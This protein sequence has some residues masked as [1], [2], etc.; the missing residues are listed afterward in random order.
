MK[1][2]VLKNSFYGVS[3][4]VSHI[5]SYHIYSVLKVSIEIAIYFNKLAMKFNLH[6]VNNLVEII[7]IYYIKKADGN[8]LINY[9]SLR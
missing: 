2:L 4:V 3:D 7:C 9:L 5:A 6:Q 8:Y 1:I